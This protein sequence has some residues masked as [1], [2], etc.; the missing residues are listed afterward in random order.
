MG[1]EFTKFEEY[2]RHGESRLDELTF[3]TASELAAAIR[4]HRASAQE[5]LEA[6]LKRITAQNP[7]LNAIVTLDEE[8]AQRRAKEADEALAHGEI[9]GPLHGVPVTIKDVFE[10]AGMR[11]TSGFK[12]LTEHGPKQRHI[13]E[14]WENGPARQPDDL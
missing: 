1:Q 3:L 2:D 12:P 6:H 10:T 11:T 4:Q 5:V 9:W 8:G 13:H 7:S 14:Q